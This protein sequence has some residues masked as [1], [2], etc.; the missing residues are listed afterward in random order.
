M[1]LTPLFWLLTAIDALLWFPG[2]Y[3]AIQA[4]DVAYAHSDSEIAIGIAALFFAL[5]VFCLVAPLSAWRAYRLR[6]R[7]WHAL[8]MLAV[9]IV[10]AAFLVVLLYNF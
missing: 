6:Q 10:Y 9:P 4:V 7:N 8:V 2:A 5:P 3:M 1:N